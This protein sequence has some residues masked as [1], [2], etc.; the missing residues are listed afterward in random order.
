MVSSGVSLRD[1]DSAKLSNVGPNSI[2]CFKKFHRY[3]QIIHFELNNLK[4]LELTRGSRSGG[5]Y[6]LYLPLN[7]NFQSFV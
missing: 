5:E 3:V 2:F 6:P 7:L 1:M 4:R